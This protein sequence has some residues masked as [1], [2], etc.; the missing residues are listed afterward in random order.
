MA[1]EIVRRSSGAA[2]LGVVYLVVIVGLV[3]L[4]IA[5][6]QKE[7]TPVVLVTLQTDH[8]GNELQ[9]A[10]DVKLRGIIVGSVRGVSRLRADGGCVNEQVTCVT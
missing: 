4:S 10:S 8:T 7:F 5:F 1:K 3:W 2:L 6:Y 9:D